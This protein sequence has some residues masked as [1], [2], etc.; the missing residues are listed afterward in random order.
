[1]ALEGLGFELGLNELLR[2]LPKHLNMCAAP[3][4]YDMRRSEHLD[5]RP[6]QRQLVEDPL[7]TDGI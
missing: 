7:D 3:R 2:S 5:Q 6:G 1:M 4:Q